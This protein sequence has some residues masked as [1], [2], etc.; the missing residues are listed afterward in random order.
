MMEPGTGGNLMADGQPQW[1]VERTQGM[2]RDAVR[3]REHLIA[4]FSDMSPEDLEQEAWLRMLKSQARPDPVKGA[5]STLVNTFVHRSTVDKCRVRGR[6]AQ[7]E[8]AVIDRTRRE[9]QATR[10]DL[11][12]AEAIVE[13]ARQ[14]YA[15]ALKRCKWRIAARGR[16]PIA[17]PPQRLA[18][19]ALRCHLGLGLRR[20]VRLLRVNQ[21]LRTVL[22]LR[23]VPSYERLRTVTNYQIYRFGYGVRRWDLATGE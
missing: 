3:R 17:T 11:P 1:D 2:V 18:I 9:G 13:F 7:R 4:G 19:H 20:M 21:E 23:Q 16:A 8:Q 10:D 15:R 6:T 5:A 12:E 14:A 22:G